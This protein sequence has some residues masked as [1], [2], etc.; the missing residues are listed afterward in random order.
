MAVDDVPG[1]LDSVERRMT[2][3]FERVFTSPVDALDDRPIE[4]LGPDRR[5]AVNGE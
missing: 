1:F 4:Y 5:S 2:E 3:I